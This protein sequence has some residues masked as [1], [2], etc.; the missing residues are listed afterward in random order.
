MAEIREG[1]Q[2]II[3]HPVLRVTILFWGATSVVTAGLVTALT[4]RVTRDLGLPPSAFGLIISTFGLGTVV[5]ALWASRIRRGVAWP[6]ILGGN[7]VRA[8]ALIGVGFVA[9]VELMGALAFA[10][11]VASTL[12]LIAY[13]TLRAAY[14]PDELL[15]RVG[16]TART[17]SIGLQPI[18]MLAT[19]V[20]IDLTSGS[21][22]LIV[23]G[24]ILAAL[25]VVFLPSRGLRAAS[26]DGK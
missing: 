22:T 6:Q 5:G 1:I 26:L 25:S 16:S 3:G 18:G 10:A 11:G 9:S 24:A 7:L 13:I 12:V 4:V 2:F 19:G 21:T 23:M 8:V 17:L 20:L 15:G 14:S